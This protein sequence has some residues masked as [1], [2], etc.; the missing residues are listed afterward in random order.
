VVEKIHNAKPRLDL[1]DLGHIKAPTGRGIDLNERSQR[2]VIG[3]AAAVAVSPE[4]VGT[5]EPIA[6]AR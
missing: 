3:G 6:D 5:Q 2:L 4:A 1:T